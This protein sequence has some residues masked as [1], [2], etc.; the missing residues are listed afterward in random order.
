MQIVVVFGFPGAGKSFVAEILRQNFGYFH[1]DGDLSMPDKML[2]KINEQAVV[3]DSMR[4]IFFQ[5]LIKDVIKLKSKYKKIVVSQTFI[6]EKYRQLFLQAFPKTKFIL[7]ETGLEIREKRLM[8]RKK[9][10]IDLEYSRKMCLIFDPPNL[11]YEVVGNNN[12]GEKSI[13][14]QLQ[15]LSI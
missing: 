2:K 10:P 6:K 9:F 8:Q 13:K 11:D 12:I 14:K 3:T 4:D 15:L 1:Y 7:V 5:E